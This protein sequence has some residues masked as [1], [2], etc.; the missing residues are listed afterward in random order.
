MN[1]DEIKVI[2]FIERNG[3]ITNALSRDNLGFGKMKSSQLFKNLVGNNKIER[4]GTGS[5]IHY[6][7]KI[8]Y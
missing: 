3:F 1:I 7:I 2:D 6:I 5:K 8:L 4:I